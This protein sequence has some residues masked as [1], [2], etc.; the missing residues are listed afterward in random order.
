ML[1]LTGLALGTV[2]HAANVQPARAAAWSPVDF[3]SRQRT[4]RLG[5]DQI[6]YVDEGEGP[7]AL[8]IHGWPLN[9]FHWRGSV[10]ALAKIRRC[11]VPDLMGLGYSD[12]PAD[13]DLSPTAQAGMLWRLADALGA[14]SLDLVAN[15]SGVAIA[16]LMAV[17]APDRVAS[18]LLT[19][20]D[21]HEDSPPKALEPAL[22]AAARG[23]LADMIRAH[24]ETPGFAASPQ[25]LGGICYENPAALTPESI[26]IYFKPL[27]ASPT[28][29][30]QFQRYGVAFK[31][32]PLPAIE[33][34]LRKLRAPVR[35]VWG[36]A[37]IHFGLHLAEWL[38]RSLPGSR[39][40]RRVPGAKLF[41]PEEQP[42]LIVAEA[43]ALWSERRA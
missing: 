15:D 27:L 3:R 4:I 37:D 10:P 17:Q 12:V 26:E 23:E 41:F 29:E 34:Q 21:V 32:N 36:D 24:I 13:R 6:A 16:Q 5:D 18:M 42:D 39:G 9:G 8:F 28:R 40:I 20:G 30:A 33:P 2:A 31:P 1:A 7:V 35:M 19:N 43:R 25:G 14:G 38:D 22:Q 11:L